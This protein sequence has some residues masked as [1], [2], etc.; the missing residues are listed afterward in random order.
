M[1]HPCILDNLVP[2]R[3]C[4][5]SWGGTEQGLCHAAFGP[6]L[7]GLQGAVMLQARVQL[8]SLWLCFTPAAFPFRLQEKQAFKTLP[9]KIHIIT[10]L[11][12]RL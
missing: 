3:T 11:Q 5:I 4:F 7:L 2:L 8:L 10:S 1:V 12:I 6:L 9:Q